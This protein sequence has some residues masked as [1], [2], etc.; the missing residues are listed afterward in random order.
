MG[1]AKDFLSSPGFTHA[2]AFAGG[3]AGTWLLSFIKHSPAPKAASIWLGAIFDATQ[4]TAKN[5]ERI[6]QRRNV[7][8][9]FLT[10]TGPGGETTTAS[11]IGD[12][13]A[14]PLGAL[15]NELAQTGRKE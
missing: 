11:T 10:S 9:A 1:A 15:P 2:S 12:P 14:P 13:A 7:E 8:S 6:G 5:T 3:V 4:D